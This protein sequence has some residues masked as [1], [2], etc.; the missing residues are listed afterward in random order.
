MTNCLFNDLGT[1]QMRMQESITVVANL[2]KVK[3]KS[4]GK[5]RSLAQDQLIVMPQRMGD[6]IRVRKEQLAA[7][8]FTVPKSKENGRK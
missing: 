4:K 7:T 1:R 8:P 2:R 6:R 3:W 5:A